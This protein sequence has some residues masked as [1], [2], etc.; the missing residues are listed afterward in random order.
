M[1]V[2]PSCQHSN[3][4]GFLFCEECGESLQDTANV[5]LPTKEIV[6]NSGNPSFARANWGTARFNSDS[7]IVLHVRD[8]ADPLIVR[9]ANELVLGRADTS[10]PMPPDID[11]A[12][13]GALEKGVSRIHA[14]ICRSDDTLLLV[15]KESSNGTH[16]NGQRLAADQPRVLRDGDEIRLGRLVMHIYFRATPAG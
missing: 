14:A 7:W 15:D 6:A 12:A 11:L 2:C 5:I 1:K 8:A 13:Y 9:P 4:E 3:R 10:S 16:L